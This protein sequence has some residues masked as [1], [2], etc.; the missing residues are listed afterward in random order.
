MSTG[1]LQTLERGIALLRLVSQSPE[2]IRINELAAQLGLNRPTAY[3]IVATLVDQTMVRRLE[4]GRIVMGV[5]A[6]Q[7]GARSSDSIQMLARPVLEKLA[8]DTGATSFLSMAEGETCVVVMTAEPRNTAF[9]IHYKLGTRHPIDRGAAGIA[10]LASRPERPEDSEDIQFARANG[11]SVTKGQLH[12]GAVGVSSPVVFQDAGLT[13]L[14][15]SIGVVALEALDI[16]GAAAAVPDAAAS[17]VK[18]LS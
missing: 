17:L 7:L 10:I 11:Y 18:V 4:D 6:Y 1:K 12:K 15:F 8:Q 9:N 2:G 5:G 3:R 14:E 16:D 13:G